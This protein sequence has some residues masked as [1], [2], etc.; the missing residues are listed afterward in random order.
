ML[1]SHKELEKI[2]RVQVDILKE[3][4]SVCEKLNV[5]F[6]MVHGSLLGTIRNNSFVPD[7]D[8][9]DIALFREDYEKFCVEAPKLLKEKYFVQTNKTDAKYPMEFAKVR[10]CDTTYVIENSRKLPINHGIYIDVFP[11]DYAFTKKVKLKTLKY[12]LLN[13]RISSI[14]ELGKTSFIRKCACLLAKI[15]YPSWGKAVEKRNKLLTG[16]KINDNVMITGGKLKER[17]IPYL[18]FDGAIESV[19]EGVKVYIP[20]NYDAYLTQI[21]G[22]YKNRTLIENKFSDDDNIE[23]NAC[24]VDVENSF[25]NCKY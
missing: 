24:Y 21:Y 17:S 11:I 19:F 23:I 3:V 12:K 9:I 25:K 6:F 7:D 22:D 16:E 1:I 4:S 10:D 13:L 15:I 8:D 14:L 2:N 5:K 18:W 20:K